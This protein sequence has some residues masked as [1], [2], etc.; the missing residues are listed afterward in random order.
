M[1]PPIGQR[2]EAATAWG[3]GHPCAHDQG[4]Q[5][6]GKRNVV[7]LTADYSLRKTLRV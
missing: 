1:I 7:P 2:N 6:V 5:E 3:R 4:D